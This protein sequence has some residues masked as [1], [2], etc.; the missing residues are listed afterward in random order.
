MMS[1][2]F[3]FNVSSERFKLFVPSQICTNLKHQNLRHDIELSWMV[4]VFN[5]SISLIQVDPTRH[6]IDLIVYGE[7][8]TF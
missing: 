3:A 8:K 1:E 7:A 2:R 5:W 4:S 6:L